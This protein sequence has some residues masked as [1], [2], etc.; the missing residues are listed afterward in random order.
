MLTS[1]YV[2]V[3]QLLETDMPYHNKSKVSAAL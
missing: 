2:N 1:S 3:T